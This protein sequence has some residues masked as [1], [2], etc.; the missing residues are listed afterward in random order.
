M[1]WG[2][3]IFR[4]IDRINYLAYASFYLE[5]TKMLPTE[6]PGTYQLFLL[7]RFVVKSNI[8]S[9][10]GVAPGDETSANQSTLK[11]AKR[12][13]IFSFFFF[14]RTFPEYLGIC[15][16]KVMSNFGVISRRWCKLNLGPLWGHVKSLHFS[17]RI[18][19]RRN[20]VFLLFLQSSWN[21]FLETTWTTLL[22]NNL[23]L[24]LPFKRN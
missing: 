1:E 23:D 6:H 18:D 3:T 13:G 17:E 14:C 19:R 12:L 15:G 20:G 16:E 5:E 24:L 11:K 10:N 2:F 21:N 7:E 22:Y 8:I 9:F 4:K